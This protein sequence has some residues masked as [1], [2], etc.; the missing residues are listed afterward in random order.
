[1]GQYANGRISAGSLGKEVGVN[2]LI[3]H[4]SALILPLW[5]VQREGLISSTKDL[6]V[7]FVAG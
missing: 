2:E 1:M 5:P 6:Y 3:K 4:Q 7:R